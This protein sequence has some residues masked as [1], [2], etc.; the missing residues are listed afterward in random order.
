[1]NC[2]HIDHTLAVGDIYFELKPYQ[3]MYEPVERFTFNGKD[4]TWNPDVV[5]AY[6]NP[7]GKKKLYCAEVQRTPLS[8]KQW[9]AKWKIYNYFFEEA[10]ERAKFQEWRSGKD[11]IAPNFICITTQKGARE[12]FDVNIE[13]RELKII[14]SITSLV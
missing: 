5:F 12:G 8:V 4:Y 14:D 3:W 10:Y 1:M 11:P 2:E 7:E 6:V 9:A 13:G